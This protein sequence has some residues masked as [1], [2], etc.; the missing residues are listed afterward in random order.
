MMYVFIYALVINQSEDFFL[1]VSMCPVHVERSKSWV[2]LPNNNYNKNK[3]EVVVQSIVCVYLHSLS[4]TD[5]LS[6]VTISAFHE[7]IEVFV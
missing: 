6:S 3:V 4:S 1:V 2:N 7:Y 5:V